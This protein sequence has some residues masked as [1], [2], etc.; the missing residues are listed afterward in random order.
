MYLKPPGRESPKI[1]SP[2]LIP[3]TLKVGSQVLLGL[4]ARPGTHNEPP[5]QEEKNSIWPTAASLV[6][7]ISPWLNV[8]G[9]F[10]TTPTYMISEK[11]QTL[12]MLLRTEGE[13]TWWCGIETY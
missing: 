6:V 7:D 3:S 11:Q 8:P 5:R 9:W 10:V 1:L 13:E 2:T 12:L 4:E